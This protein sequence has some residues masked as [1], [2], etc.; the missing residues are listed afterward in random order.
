MDYITLNDLV[1]V[2]DVINK[3][4]EK[5]ENWVKRDGKFFPEQKS[6]VFKKLPSGLYK[7]KFD[8]NEGGYFA[9]PQNL[10]GDQIIPINKNLDDLVSEI[11]N[12]EDDKKL[13]NDNNII[14]KRSYLL[15]GPPGT[16][17]TSHINLILNKINES[18]KDVVSI[19]IENPANFYSVK[20]FVKYFRE[21]EPNRLIVII[22]EDVDEF[23]KCDAESEFINMLDGS[24]QIENVVY[25]MTS[26]NLEE[27]PERML[28]ASRID[29]IYEIMK[30]SIDDLKLFFINK[31]KGNEELSTQLAEASLKNELSMADAKELFIS[32]FIKKKPIEDSVERIKNVLSFLQKDTYEEKSKAKKG[33]KIGCFKQR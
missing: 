19:V 20:D 6:K 3:E 27:F 31:T 2:E 4:D 7:I 24:L 11:V 28:R 16:G 29:E 17:K 18:K 9:I 12:F 30:P 8:R 13:Y 1:E 25:L 22:I 14:F 33:K 26:N 23:F 32:V 5:F 21:I 10:S 15:C